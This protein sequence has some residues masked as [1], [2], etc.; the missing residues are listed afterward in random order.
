MKQLTSAKEGIKISELR[1]F[2]RIFCSHLIDHIQGFPKKV[3]RL[4][5][6]LKSIFSFILPS[7]P[8]LSSSGIFSF[9]ETGALFWE[10]RY[11]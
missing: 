4:L 7:L 11:F 5:K 10:T 9:C 1:L 3:A 6:H 2:Q 8:S